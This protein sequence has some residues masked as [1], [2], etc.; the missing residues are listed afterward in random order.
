MVG[1]SEKIISWL[2]RGNTDGNNIIRERKIGPADLARLLTGVARADDLLMRIIKI[3]IDSSRNKERL[4]VMYRPYPSL[5]S[6]S[7]LSKIKKKQTARWPQF[8]SGFRELISEKVNFLFAHKRTLVM[9]YEPDKGRRNQRKPEFLVKMRRGGRHMSGV[10][11]LILF[12]L[13]D[14]VSSHISPY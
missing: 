12:L 9:K 14:F 2:S 6:I 13:H 5:R 11:R 4:S 3:F 1:E 7:L 10:N 8:V